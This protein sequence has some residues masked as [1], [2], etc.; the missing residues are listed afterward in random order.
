M[1]KDF[2]AGVSEDFSAGVPTHCSSIILISGDI[3]S[4]SCPSFLFLALSGF[5]SNNSSSS[6][7][8]ASKFARFDYSQGGPRMIRGCTYI[9]LEG[10][11]D[12]FVVQRLP[13]DPLEPRMCLNIGE[14][15]PTWAEP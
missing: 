3:I 9:W 10:G 7:C 1:I 5:S 14:P 4:M 15:S 12:L 11:N 6:S 2:E 8:V 13:V